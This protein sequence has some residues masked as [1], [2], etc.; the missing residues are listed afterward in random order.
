MDDDLVWPLNVTLIVV[1]NCFRGR[2]VMS[3]TCG[4]KKYAGRYSIRFVMPHQLIRGNL[5]YGYVEEGGQTKKKLENLNS[6]ICKERQ[7]DR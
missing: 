6:E 5:F 2:A 3:V 4:V 1:Y 7:R